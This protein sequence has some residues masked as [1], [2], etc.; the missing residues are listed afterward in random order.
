MVTGGLGK[1][2]AG[3]R[4]TDTPFSPR[5]SPTWPRRPQQ[6]MVGV[7][8]ELGGFCRFIGV[9]VI[10]CLS[11][12]VT[13]GV[14]VRGSAAY[15]SFIIWFSLLSCPTPGYAHWKG[16]VLTAEELHVLYE[17][18]KLNQ[19]NRYDYILTGESP[20]ASDTRERRRNCR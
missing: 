5:G 17:G 13:G 1:G 11:V 7:E 18:I 12:H 6:M 16:Q 9:K 14:C 20:V 19:V 3:S 2:E 15:V 4:N 10:L 8:D